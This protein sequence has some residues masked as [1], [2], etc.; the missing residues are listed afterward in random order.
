MH[1]HGIITQEIPA[2]TNYEP[3]MLSGKF[4]SHLSIINFNM[5]FQQYFFKINTRTLFSHDPSMLKIYPKLPKEPQ[6]N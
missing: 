4:E 2:K 3:S 1:I 6:C 5:S